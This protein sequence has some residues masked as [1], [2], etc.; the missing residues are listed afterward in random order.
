[1]MRSSLRHVGVH[2]QYSD[3]SIKCQL[4]LPCL[5]HGINIPQTSKQSIMDDGNPIRH[6]SIV[7][8]IM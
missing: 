1:M 5:K 2:E 3:I 6:K 4:V 7:F 8:L